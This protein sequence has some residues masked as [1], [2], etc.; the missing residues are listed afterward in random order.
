MKCHSW[1]APFPSV[2]GQYPLSGED[3]SIRKIWNGEMLEEFAASFAI[4]IMSYSLMDNHYHIILRNHSDLVI[5]YDEIEVAKRWWRICP[6]IRDKDNRAA[7]PDLR[8]LRIWSDAPE[9]VGELRYRL[10]SNSW[11]TQLFN[12][13]VARRA[14]A[15][16]G[17]AVKHFLGVDGLSFQFSQFVYLI[18]T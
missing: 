9:V 4:D 11:M 12:A 7:E 17:N 13:R 10:T 3:R 5:G 6:G 14:H 15:E 18:P 1:L 16:S 8:D 2:C